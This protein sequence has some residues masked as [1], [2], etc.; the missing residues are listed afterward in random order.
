MRGVA[1][2]A[3]FADGADHLTDLVGRRG[4]TEGEDDRHHH[5]HHE[6]AGKI[7][8]ENETPIAQHTAQRH[9][10]TLVDQCQRA[11]HEYAGQEVEAEQIKHAEADREKR[12]ADDRNPGLDVDGHRHRRGERENGAGHIGADHRIAC[13]H[14]DFGF[15]GVDHLGHEFRR[16]EIGHSSSPLMRS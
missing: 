14:E 9:A 1:D 12:G 3:A 6:G 10:G 11:E 4:E 16:H 13:R 7:A 8:D 15:S 5:R 2:G